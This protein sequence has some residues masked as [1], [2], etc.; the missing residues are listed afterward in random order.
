MLPAKYLVYLYVF[1][2]AQTLLKYL[3]FMTS[4]ISQLTEYLQIN[5]ITVGGKGAANISNNVMGKVDESKKDK[6]TK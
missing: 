3:L 5:I 4:I 1:F 2:F 6:K